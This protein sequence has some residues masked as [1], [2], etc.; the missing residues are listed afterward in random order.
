MMPAHAAATRLF[1]VL[2]CL[3]ALAALPGCTKVE[4]AV[5]NAMMGAERSLAGLEEAR[6]T[7][8]DIDWVYLKNDWQPQRE[9]VVLLHGYTGN[10]DNWTRFAGELASAY[11]LVVPD[12][13]GH[14]DTT[15]TMDIAYDIDTQARRVA[16]LMAALGI[17]KYHLAGN[18]MGGAISVRTAWLAPA[19]VASVG[20]FNAAGAKAQDSEFDA[21]IK[22]GVNPLVVREPEDF[23]RVI[24]WATADPPFIPW[25]V[26]RVMGRQGAERAA[27]H[28]KIFTDL[29]RD[30][31]NDQTRILPEVVA[32]TLVLWGDQDRLLHVANADV[33]VTR[34]P[35]ARKVVMPG[36]GHA[37]MLEAPAESAEIYRQFLAGN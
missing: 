29:R 12:L 2:A 1:T 10:K 33:F 23:D 5:F 26:S 3:L 35:L 36:I 11:N 25:P 37:P 15:H 28:D 34:M 19:H 18:S 7:V 13:P 30:D 6:V 16:S 8:D 32:R 22:R 17:E 20:L 31:G 14:G 27:L 24:A 9:T 21:E 4:D